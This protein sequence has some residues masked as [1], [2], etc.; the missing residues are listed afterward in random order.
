MSNAAASGGYYIAMNSEK[1]FAQPTTITGSIGVFGIKFDATKWAKSYGVQSDH[2]PHGNHEAA[3]HP[4]TPLAAGPRENIVR[5]IRE[6]YDYFKGIVAAGRSL[7]AKEV[8]EVA[9]GRVWTGAQAKEAGL[10]DALGGL[11]R[12]ISHARAAYATSGRVEIEHWPK[13]SFRL[14]DLSQLLGG[15]ELSCANFVRASLA[16]AAGQE[17]GSAS[18]SVDRYFRGLVELKFAEK[19]HFMLTMDENTAL[20]IIMSGE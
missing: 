4:L 6:Y 12:A 3:M 17:D 14:E 2:H 1:I 16:V 5:M 15:R 18:G 13:S 19:P 11:D 20:E 7:S 10:V 9:Q 8:E